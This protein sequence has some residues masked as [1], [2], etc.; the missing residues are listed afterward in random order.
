M[1]IEIVGYW[2]IFS[3]EMPTKKTNLPLVQPKCEDKGL[4]KP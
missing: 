2:D 3:L 4:R 1:D